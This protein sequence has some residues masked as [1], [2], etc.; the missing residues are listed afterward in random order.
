[1]ITYRFRPYQDNH[2][3]SIME[4]M[5]LSPYAG[6][7]PVGVPVHWLDDDEDWLAAPELGS[8]GHV[9]QQDM[10]NLEHMHR[11]LRNNTRKK[12]FLGRYQELKIRHF[13]SLYVQDMHL[14]Q[15]DLASKGT[16]QRGSTSPDPQTG[17]IH[18]P[19]RRR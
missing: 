19:G 6:E 13:Y 14:V 15:S 18:D 4:C 1:L 7:R 10:L 9:F 8:L 11:G 16:Q 3:R 2:Q 17:R 5:F 12:V